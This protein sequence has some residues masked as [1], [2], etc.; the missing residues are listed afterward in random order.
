L[1]EVTTLREAVAGVVRDGN[2]L[3]LEGFTHLIPSAVG[4]EITKLDPA[5]APQ[6]GKLDVETDR[7]IRRGCLRRARSACGVGPSGP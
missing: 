6:A 2:S 1:A 5:R 7:Y 3:A 4:H